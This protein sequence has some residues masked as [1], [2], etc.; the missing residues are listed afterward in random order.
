MERQV[1]L[2][3]PVYQLGRINLPKL[4]YYYA[5]ENFETEPLVYPVKF[6]YISIHSFKYPFTNITG[7]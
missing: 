4:C 2:T 3:I 1:C 5:R 6:V 7:G